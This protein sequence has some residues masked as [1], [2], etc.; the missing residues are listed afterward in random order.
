MLGCYRQGPQ[1]QAELRRVSLQVTSCPFSQ[2][3][4]D[5]EGNQTPSLQS[6]HTTTPGEQQ[7]GFFVLSTLSEQI[8]VAWSADRLFVD[9]EVEKASCQESFGLLVWHS[10]KQFTDILFPLSEESLWVAT[11]AASK[12]THRL[13]W[14]LLCLTFLFLLFLYQH[15]HLSKA[16]GKSLSACDTL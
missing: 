2:L 5:Q 16:F 12:A 10:A 14:T 6:L 9:L 4:W 7:S 1:W 13:K 15:Q 11:V 8:C 3:L